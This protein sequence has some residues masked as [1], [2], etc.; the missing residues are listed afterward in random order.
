M[1]TVTNYLK[2]CFEEL[3][4]VTWPSRQKTT[5]YTVLVIAMSIGMA[6]FFLIIDN[7]LDIGLKYLVDNF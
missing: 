7:A 1:N 5:T 6:L 4:K 2:E 3:K